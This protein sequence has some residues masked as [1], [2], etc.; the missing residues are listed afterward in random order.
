M[1]SV[2]E[3]IK[4]YTLCY[5]LNVVT[6]IHEIVQC[7]IHLKKSNTLLKAFKYFLQHNKQNQVKV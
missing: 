5:V 6:I 3:L 2:T 4:Y 7:I 1:H